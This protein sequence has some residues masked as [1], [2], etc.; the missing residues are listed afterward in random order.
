MISHWIEAMRLRTLP[1]SVAGVIT[2]WAYAM[3]EGSFNTLAAGLCLA[4][5]LLGQ[6]ASNFANEY[7][8]YK[9]GI[10]RPGREGPRR[11]VT[12][13]D[14][15]PRAM[16][17]ATYLTLGLCGC[18]GLALAWMA[19][20]WLLLIG[21]AILLGALAYSTGPFPLS[22][23]GL[24]EVAVIIFFGVVPVI[25][26]TYT[27]GGEISTES[28]Y[29]SV[30]IGLLAANVLV[31]NN[32]RD[33]DDDRKVGKNT[34]AVKLG[35]QFMPLLYALNALIALALMWQQW[36]TKLVPILIGI[37]A[38]IIAVRLRALKGT[39]LNPMLGIT[40]ML[41]F[42]YSLLFILL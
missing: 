9:N 40:A 39:K 17:N 37:V 33:C 26:T 14:I 24:G 36:S 32:Y 31:V 19:G 16:R 22:Q 38:I 2:G 15:T 29:G 3:R 12:E 21:I 8:D 6:I 27:V 4:V 18:C 25:F 1:V 35:S 23:N 30:C 13:G 42:L 34:L 10:D 20:W 11:G 41:L 7:Y 28:V 5:A